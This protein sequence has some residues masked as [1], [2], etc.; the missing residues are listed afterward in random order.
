VTDR[1]IVIIGGGAVAARKAAGAI[2]AGATKVRVI[3][4]DF[5]KTMPTNVEK[6][7]AEYSSN[8]LDGAELVFAATNNPQ[9]NER[10]VG[11]ARA[12]KIFV[13]RAD[14][15][16]AGSDQ[17]EDEASVGDFLTPALFRDGRVTVAIS[18]GGNPALA[19]Y[20]RDQLARSWQ[21]GW[22]KMADAMQALR[23]QI[24][25]DSRIPIERRKAIFKDL[26]TPEAIDALDAGGLSA[27]REWLAKRHPEIVTH[28]HAPRP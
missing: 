3:S 19:A 5:C 15:A 1:R 23:P 28:T 9:V 13:S 2:A 24:R 7:V 6:I 20:I 4:P 27:L 8:H 11:D 17:S 16:G 22:S 18:A 26:A 14:G 12:R 10:I 25:Q 21:G